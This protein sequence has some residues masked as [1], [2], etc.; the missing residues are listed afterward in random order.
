LDYCSDAPV[1]CAP[2]TTCD[3]STDSCICPPSGGGTNTND[4]CQACED[5]S[6][7]GPGGFCLYDSVYSDWFGGGSCSEPCNT[8]NSCPQA[9]DICYTITDSNDNPIGTGCYPRSQTCE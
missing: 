5:N 1:E 8:D 3:S 6:D 7:C 9:G 2:V 4:Y